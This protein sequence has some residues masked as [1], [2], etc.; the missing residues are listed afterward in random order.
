MKR[1]TPLF[2]EFYRMR[3][4]SIAGVLL[5]EKSSDLIYALFQLCEKNNISIPKGID[6]LIGKTDSMLKRI[7]DANVLPILELLRLP[8][9]AL[10]PEAG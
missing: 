4:T 10:S 2:D 9:I 1:E 8:P 3:Q 6:R 7:E 5:A